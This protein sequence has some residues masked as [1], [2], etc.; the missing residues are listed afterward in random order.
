MEK[1]IVVARISIAQGKEKEFLQLV[2][3]LLEN[4]KSETG[5]LVYTIYKDL[6]NDS[7]FIVYEEYKDLESFEAH[8]NSEYFLHFAHKITPLLSKDL[9]IQVF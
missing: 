7:E 4:T 2:A 5:N 9:D 6:Y 1:K 8:A 3:P